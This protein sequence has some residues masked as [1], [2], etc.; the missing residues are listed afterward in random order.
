MDVTPDRST[1]QARS[2]HATRDRLLASATTLFAARGLYGV[3]SH[4]IAREAG[5]AA[6]TFYLHF[7]DKTEIF[8]QI[9]METVDRLRSSIQEAVATTGSAAE[10]ALA[11][12][13]RI[14]AFAEEHRDLVRIVFTRDSEATAVEADVMAKM[15]EGLTT[16]LAREQADGDFPADLDP[17]VAA[18]ALLGMQVRLIDW[19][20]EDPR[21][22]TRE[23]IIHTLVRLQMHG[24]GPLP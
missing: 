4:D 11:R 22:A 8:R 10:A 23:K 6:G 15:S 18:Q 20:T 14:V 12:A 21:R 9:A 17:A 24:T 5:V 3:T 7:K 1:A 2:R 19:W 13:E 16:R